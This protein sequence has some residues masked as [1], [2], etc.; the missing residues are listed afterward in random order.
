M[1]M[2]RKRKTFSLTVSDAPMNIDLVDKISITE[3]WRISLEL[4]FFPPRS[5]NFYCSLSIYQRNLILNKIL[6]V[7]FLR[8]NDPSQRLIRAKC[9]VHNSRRTCHDNVGN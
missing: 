2:F 7:V 3:K 1:V 8:S 6:S 5:H 4:D 9:I